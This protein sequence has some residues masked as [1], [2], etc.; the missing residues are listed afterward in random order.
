MIILNAPSV[1]T[2]LFSSLPVHNYR[3][4]S[5]LSIK[6]ADFKASNMHVDIYELSDFLCYLPLSCDEDEI[7]QWA[8]AEVFKSQIGTIENNMSQMAVWYLL[9]S[10]SLRL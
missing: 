7:G 10:L 1:V 6:D 2:I 8:C 5:L 4:W 9:F 3:F